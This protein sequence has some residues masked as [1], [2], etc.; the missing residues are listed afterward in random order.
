[1]SLRLILPEEKRESLAN[2][3]S[4]Q[5]GAKYYFDALAL[6]YHSFYSAF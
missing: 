2:F 4:S 6:I 3:L 5:K 1:M